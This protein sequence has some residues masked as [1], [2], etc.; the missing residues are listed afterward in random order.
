[1]GKE[2]Q[3]IIGGKYRVV[4]N[5]KITQKRDNNMNNQPLKNPITFMSD[6]NIR[7]VTSHPRDVGLANFCSLIDL[8]LGVTT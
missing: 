7:G 5:S 4:T 6:I 8:F 3:P 1:M 2:N